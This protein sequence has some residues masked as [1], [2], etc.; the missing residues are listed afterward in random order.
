MD[1]YSYL[2]DLSLYQTAETKIE[3]FWI[4]RIFG[5]EPDPNRQGYTIFPTFLTANKQPKNYIS[6]SHQTQASVNY[7]I[8]CYFLQTNACQ[9]R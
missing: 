7:M 5:S 8:L 1:N 3:Q 6:T 4:N 9:I 2:N